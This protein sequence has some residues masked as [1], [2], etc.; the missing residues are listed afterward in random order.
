MK[1]NFVKR[2]L[3]TVLS[4]TMI[5]GS[6]TACGSGSD[7]ASTDNSTSGESTTAEN[8]EAQQTTS[9]GEGG[10]ILWLSNLSSGIQY[11]TTV[12][13]LTAICDELG[14]HL[15]IAY[16]DSFNDAAGNLSAVKNA[17]TSDVV[18]L[19]ASQDGGLASIMEEYPDL[20]VAGY[21]TEM[22]SVYGDGGEN[23]AVLDNEHFLGTIVDGSADGADM[24]QLFFDTVVDKGYKKIAVVNFPSYAYPNQ[25]VA[26]STFKELVNEYNATASDADKIEIVGETTTLEF[27]PLEDSWFLEDGH[28]DLDC[29]V[30]LCAGIQFVYPTMATAIANGTCSA[31][32]KMITGGFDTDESIVSAIGDD[33]PMTMVF[34]SPAEDPAYAIVLLDNAING[35]QYADW[36]N[37]RVD[38][39]TY[40][41]DSTEDINNVMTKSMAGTA[42][43]SLAQLSVDD[44]VNKLCVRNNP[45]A[46]Y[47]D[48]IDALHDDATIGVDALK[49]R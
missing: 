13:Y 20:Y 21:N 10:T 40:M 29:I 12:T 44:V 4:T 27:T 37:D 2:V 43:V 1:K 48:L 49:N 36:T 34:F 9:T 35:C 8:S 45:D 32:T 11:E 31:D 14:Y 15:S 6:L 25:A 39:Y 22:N 19:I 7:A 24:A 46:T 5:V 26:D 38:S 3:A 23:A 47:A 16:G 30:S 42:D 41:I 18:G 33:Q 17:M 28:S